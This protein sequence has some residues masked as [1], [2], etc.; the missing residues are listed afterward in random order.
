M[1]LDARIAFTVGSLFALIFTAA[2]GVETDNVEFSVETR[3]MVATD[4]ICSPYRVADQLGGDGLFAMCGS[5]NYCGDGHIGANEACDDGVHN[6][7]YNYCNGDCTGLAAYCG[8]GVKNGPELC[9]GEDAGDAPQTSAGAPGCVE[10]CDCITYG[11]VSADNKEAL[12]AYA[13]IEC[14]EFQSLT[15]SNMPQGTDLNELAS[16]RAVHHDVLIEFNAAL[17]NLLG[18]LNSSYRDGMGIGHLETIGGTLTVQFN[19]ALNSC[20]AY[21]DGNGYGHDLVSQTNKECNNDAFVLDN[22][23]SYCKGC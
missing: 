16:L 9:D 14:L 13:N 11:D 17:I 2:C 21:D 19:G 20:Q 10:S 3:D 4:E 1:T 23:E 7:E 15:V 22:D 12:A 6:G 18:L 8:D 5:A